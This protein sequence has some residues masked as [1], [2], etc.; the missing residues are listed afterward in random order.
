MGKM[1]E[2]MMAIII[3]AVLVVS[4][5][6]VIAAI[7]IA[8]AAEQSNVTPSLAIVGK[9]L[10]FS[11]SLYIKYGIKTEGIDTE[12]TK[13]QLLVWSKPQDKYIKGTETEVIYDSGVDAESGYLI[14]D[15]KSLAAKQMTDVV[16]ARAYV[17]IEGLD[18]YSEPSKYSVLEYA[19]NKLG[20]TGTAS[21]DADYIQLLHDMLEYGALAQQYKDYKLDSLATDDFYALRLKNGVL[22][23]DGFNFGLYKE[24]AKVRI[25]ARAAKADEQF[26]GW[27]DLSTGV[28]VSEDVEYELTMTAKE[29]RYEAVYNMTSL[30]GFEFKLN[31]DGNTYSFAGIGTYTGLTVEIPES[32]NGKPVTTIADGAFANSHVTSVTLPKTI[33][34]IGAGAF[35]GCTALTLVE[36]KGTDKEWA[37]VV[38]ADGWDGGLS[39]TIKAQ[40]DWGM[41]P[42]PA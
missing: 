32:Y 3:V 5:T 17:Q 9:N 24:G 31:S 28:I 6:V 11:D 4:A 14:F 29:E 35:N 40:K 26:I 42:L 12:S 19:Y 16:Y 13:V 34:K 30:E 23:E 1:S 25:K 38:K 22:A 8:N 37:S 18:Y 20:I 41:G 36:Y 39:F 33:V 7:S 27:K 2:K 10:S 21:T 15:Y